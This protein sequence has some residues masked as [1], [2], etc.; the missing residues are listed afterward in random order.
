MFDDFFVFIYTNNYLKYYRKDAEMIYFTGNITNIITPP[1]IYGKIGDSISM[2]VESQDSITLKLEKWDMM[3]PSRGTLNYY[4]SPFNWCYYNTSTKWTMRE[5]EI[6]IESEDSGSVVVGSMKMI[7]TVGLM[8]M[9]NKKYVCAENAGAGAL[10]ANRE[11]VRSWETFEMSFLTN[12]T[13]SLK[14][15]A[16]NKYVCAEN[17]GAAPLIANRDVVRSWETFEI[18]FLSKNNISLKSKANNKYV[19]AENMGAGQLIANKDTVGVD[20]TFTIAAMF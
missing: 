19:C 10:I 5:W 11:K 14:S 3:Y 4:I 8:S 1:S 20:E 15:M 6:K 13:I 2:C 17:A 9:A 16:N 12:S 7:D 18:K